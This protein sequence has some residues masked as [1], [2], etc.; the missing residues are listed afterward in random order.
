M[1]NTINGTTTIRSQGFVTVGTSIAVNNVMIIVIDIRNVFGNTSSKQPM[2]L[3]NRFTI[4]PT[5]LESKNNTGAW[6]TATTILS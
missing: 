4:L 1:T 6:R 5:G 2:S 3:E